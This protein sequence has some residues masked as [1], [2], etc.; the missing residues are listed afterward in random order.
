[1]NFVTD[2]LPAANP[3]SPRLTLPTCSDVGLGGAA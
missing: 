1:V 3:T 2:A